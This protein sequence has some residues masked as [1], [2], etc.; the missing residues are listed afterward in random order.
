MDNLPTSLLL[1]IINPYFIMMVIWAWNLHPLGQEFL[2]DSLSGSTIYMAYYT[3]AHLLHNQDMYG[4]TNTGSPVALDQLTDEVWDFIF[5]DGPYPTASDIPSS[6]LKKM[7]H[8]SK[9]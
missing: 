5:C 9:Y 6:I 4:R 3:I 8:E 7:K 2:V 1:I